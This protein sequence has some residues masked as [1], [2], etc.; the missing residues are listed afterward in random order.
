MHRQHTTDLTTPQTS[1]ERRIETA[2]GLLLA[3]AIGV[4]LAYGLLAWCL[5]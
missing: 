5:Q 1:A 2:L 4:G 3:A